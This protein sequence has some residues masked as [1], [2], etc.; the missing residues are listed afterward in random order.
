MSDCHKNSIE[1]EFF[2][3]KRLIFDRKEKPRPSAEE[4]EKGSK[5]VLKRLHDAVERNR[6]GHGVSHGEKLPGTVHTRREDTRERYRPPERHEDTVAMAQETV[7]LKGKMTPFEVNLMQGVH[8]NLHEQYMNPAFMMH[9]RRKGLA[10]KVYPVLDRVISRPGDFEYRSIGNNEVHIVKRRPPTKE[11]ADISE[12]FLIVLKTA[13]G[14]IARVNDGT[15][16][17]NFETASGIEWMENKEY[18]E[19]MKHYRKRFWAEYNQKGN[20]TEY[21]RVDEEM[22]DPERME[23]MTELMIEPYANIDKAMQVIFELENITFPNRLL[24]LID[25]RGLDFEKK[26]DPRITKMRDRMSKQGKNYEEITQKRFPPDNKLQVIVI[27][28]PDIKGAYQILLKPDPGEAWDSE[29]CIINITQEGYLLVQ[30]GNGQWVADPRYTD[31]V[32]IDYYAQ[33]PEAQVALSEDEKKALT[34]HSKQM[35]GRVKELE[36][37]KKERLKKQKETRDRI[38]VE[39]ALG[40]ASLDD[41]K[42]AARAV[43]PSEYHK[44]IDAEKDA[45][46]MRAKFGV[47]LDDPD[48]VRK[49]AAALNID[50]EESTE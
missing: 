40:S 11:N 30:D 38:K 49:I 14:S 42:K 37:A 28:H 15:N 32:K 12:K 4:A 26:D 20:W 25:A 13:Q 45:E 44:A 47:F 17:M 41:L 43:S 19:Q 2:I 35:E 50:L 21:Y 34:E 23:R 5:A 7:K 46:T 18:N 29:N 1:S 39:A 3:E 8:K 22:E 31:Y 48:S 33:N 9:L 24:A 10:D 36:E 6:K 27:P 16:D